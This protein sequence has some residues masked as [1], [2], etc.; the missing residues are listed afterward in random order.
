MIEFHP[1]ANIFPMLGEAELQALAADIKAHGQREAIILHP[2]CERIIDGRN[3]HRAC[4]LAGVDGW[5]EYWSAEECGPLLPYVVS[6]NVHRRHLDASQRSMVAAEIAT[7]KQGERT[8][9]Q[10]S[11]SLQKVSV[12]EASELMSVSPRSTQAARKVKEQGAPELVAAVVQGAITVSDAATILDEPVEV[13][14]EIVRRVE[15]GEKTAKKAKAKIK[16]KAKVEAA[17][18]IRFDSPTVYNVLYADPPWSYSNSGVIA[19]AEKHYPTMPL[20]DLCSFLEGSG[21]QTAD[22]AVLFMWATNPTLED[23]FKVLEGWGFNYKTNVAW[24]KTERKKP[25]VGFYVRG[26]HELLIIATKGSFLPLDRSKVV[27]SVIE[28]PIREHSRKPDD[29]HDLIERLYP[30]GN[31][32]EIFARSQREGWST[33]GNETDKF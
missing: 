20:K 9:T 26:W 30:G 33:Y 27:G 23:A 16:R 14:Q 5:Y 29:F 19:A 2:D 32:I 3:R 8:D 24:V 15:A 17:Q 11:A 12:S 10:P 25:G 13:Q 21:I 18:A 7:M 4:E 28:A 1:V 22:N 6:L 31:Y